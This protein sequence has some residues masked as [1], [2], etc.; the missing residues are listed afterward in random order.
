MSATELTV[1]E[2]LLSGLFGASVN[3]PI[4]IPDRAIILGL[5]TRTVAAISGAASYDCGI[6]GEPA[7]RQVS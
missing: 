1:A 7:K 5:S 2:E 6:E 4:T 3:S